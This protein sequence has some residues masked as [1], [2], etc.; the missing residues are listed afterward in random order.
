MKGLSTAM[1]VYGNVYDDK[2]PTADKWCDLLIQEVDMSPESFKCP[3]APE[4]KSNY[5]LNKNFHKVGGPES[6]R[7]VAIFESQPGWNQVGGPELLTTEH[8]Y[9]E[10]CNVG[11]GDGHVEFI[12]SDRINDL[13]WGPDE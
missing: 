4:G 7:T 2:V 13:Y 8:H 1:M 9:G 3:A 12:E 10:G 6:E 11:F 5:A